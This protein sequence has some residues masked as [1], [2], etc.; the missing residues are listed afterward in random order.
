MPASVAVPL[1]LSVNVTPLGSAPDSVIVGVGT[2]VVVT[3]SVPALPTVKVAL[4]AL[5]MV[6][7]A[8]GTHDGNLNVPTRVC[9]LNVP[10][11]RR[12]AHALFAIKSAKR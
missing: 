11:P 10:F 4:F 1:A 5:V 3:V 7:A 9:Q 2:P 8:S 6:G 12:V